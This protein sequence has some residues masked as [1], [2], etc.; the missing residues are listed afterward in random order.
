[1]PRTKRGSL[2]EQVKAGY[3]RFLSRR[4]QGIGSISP[5][6]FRQQIAAGAKLAK[7]QKLKEKTP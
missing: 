2:E 7:Q 1:M 6:N 3:Q 5:M 4:K